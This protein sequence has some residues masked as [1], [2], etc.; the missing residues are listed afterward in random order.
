M[1][2]IDALSLTDSEGKF[3]IVCAKPVKGLDLQVDAKGAMRANFE[4]VASGEEQHRLS[5]EKG[6]TVVGRVVK[7]GRGVA[8]VAVGFNQGRH[9]IQHNLGTWSVET[10]TAGRF[11]IANLP[12]GEEL[13]VAGLIDSL[14]NQ[15]RSSP[16][17]SAPTG[18][19]YDLG[20]LPIVPAHRV[21]GRLVLGDGKAV[22]AGTQVVFARDE[23]RDATVVDADADG[24][25]AVTG[26][27]PEAVSVRAPIQGYHFSP[28]N[29]SFEPLNTHGLLGRVAGDV[30]DLLIL[31]EP[32]QEPRVDFADGDRIESLLA[33]RQRLKTEPLAG[34]TAKFEQPTSADAV[35][36]SSARVAGGDEPAVAAQD[37][38]AAG[39][40]TANPR[41]RGSGDRWRWQSGRRRQRVVRNLLEQ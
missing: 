34:V 17:S 18:A 19:T 36:P 3:A 23:S 40:R 31:L 38:S 8:G 27:P 7:E 4:L 26:I 10:D 15:A 32:G 35:A 9:G 21:A 13:F 20:D 2:G 30:D 25:F 6:A 39:R 41:V 33:R 24:D 14:R 11:S 12:I 5:L 22:P 1:P 37:R 28:K 16:G 29:G